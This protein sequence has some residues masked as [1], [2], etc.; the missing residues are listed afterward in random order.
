M[1]VWLNLTD[2]DDVLIRRLLLP[3]L[4]SKHN[5][6]D[7]VVVGIQH[8]HHNIVNSGISKWMAA[9]IGQIFDVD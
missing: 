4:I 8:T 2:T 3:P 1:F 7:E 6:E 5:D 9:L